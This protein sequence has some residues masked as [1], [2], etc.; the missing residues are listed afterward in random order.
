MQKSWD[1]WTTA[2]LVVCV[3]L[4]VHIVD[5]VVNGSFGLYEDVGRV[6]MIVF[7]SLELPPFQRDVWLVNLGGTLIVL[8]A[9]TW[10]VRARSPLMATASYLLAA[11]A[12][13]NGV[14]HLLAVAALKGLVPGAWTA[15]VLI[16]AGLYLFTSIPGRTQRNDVR[17][18]GV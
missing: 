6:L 13:A 10:W 7:P 12:T 8:F 5:E 18:A 17:A 3:V 2:W 1:H 16:A 14:L 11:F 9:L 15:P 4:A